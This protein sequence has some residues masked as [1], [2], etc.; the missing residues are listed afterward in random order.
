MS[1]LLE[2]FDAFVKEKGLCEGFDDG[3]IVKELRQFLEEQLEGKVLVDVEPQ[4]VCAMCL[5]TLVISADS[6]ERYPCYQCMPKQTRLELSFNN[7][8]ADNQLLYGSAEFLNKGIVWQWYKAQQPTTDERG[9][10]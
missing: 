5:D 7:M 9:E 2:K 8:V 1:D 6:G 10:G 4:E 3:K